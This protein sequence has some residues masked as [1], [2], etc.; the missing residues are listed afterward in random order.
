MLRAVTTGIIHRYPEVPIRLEPDV[1]ARPLTALMQR[2]LVIIDKPAGCTS[3][4]VIVRV[5]RITRRKRVGHS[6]TLDPE[7]T[8]VLPIGLGQ[9]TRMLGLLLASGKT[10]D[11]EMHLHADEPAERV[12]EVLESQVG[13]ITQ[14][15]PV[16][17]RVKRVERE[18]EIHS[19]QIASIGRR[20]VRFTV[21]CEAGTYIRK[22]CHDVGVQLGCGAHMAWLR[23][24]NAGG[25]TLDDA[26]T[27]EQ[28]AEAMA[29]WKRDGNEAPLRAMLQSAESALDDDLPRVWVDD[30]AL[31][32]ISTGSPMALPGVIAFTDNLVPG[33]DC[34]LMS[35]DGWFVAI[36]RVEDGMDVATVREH[37]RGIF[38][39]QHHV[40]WPMP[41]G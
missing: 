29:A 31:V 30:G 9:A 10:Y 34:A 11:C 13:T 20:N 7:V 12:R 26:V 15:P 2:S 38:A 6:G 8:G 24:L 37:G 25:Y 5:R 4:D 22:L 3:H 36:A 33:E 39:R 1:A 35:T 14:L 16:R 41:E 40:L 18:R 19:L 27:I 21:E 23:R 32:P 28:L 17:S